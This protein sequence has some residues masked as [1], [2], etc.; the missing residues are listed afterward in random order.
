M[1]QVCTE[2]T[3]QSHINLSLYTSC[4]PEFSLSTLQFKCIPLMMYRDVNVHMRCKLPL[5]SIL[6]SYIRGIH[7]VTMIYILHIYI[8]IYIATVVCV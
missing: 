1:I 6:G 7:R 8:Y 5:T 4:M 2:M 3:L